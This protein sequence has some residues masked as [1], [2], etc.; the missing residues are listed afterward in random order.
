MSENPHDNHTT[1][2]DV[3]RHIM[4]MARAGEGRPIFI[5]MKIVVPPQ[6]TPGGRTFVT[7]GDSTEPEVEVHRIGDRVALVT[8]L[9]GMSPGQVQVLFRDDRVFIWARDNERQYQASACVPPAVR[10]SVE[11][12]CRHGVLEVAYLPLHTGPEQKEDTH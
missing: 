3:L 6:E 1:I 8:E 5:G 10:E 7:R 9:P 11:V 12:S 2:E 4:E